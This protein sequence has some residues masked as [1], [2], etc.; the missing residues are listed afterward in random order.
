MAQ[1][2]HTIPLLFRLN[3][4]AFGLISLRKTLSFSIPSPHFLAPVC[5]SP[6]ADLVRNARD[7]STSDPDPPLQTGIPRFTPHLKQPP[8]YAAPARLARPSEAQT[9]QPRHRSQGHVG[10]RSLLGHPTCSPVTALMASH[11]RLERKACPRTDVSSACS[12]SSVPRVLQHGF[13]C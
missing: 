2:A 1:Q 11:A 5:A 7:S 4:W 6:L 12:C 8:P 9:E 10:S 13:S 3:A